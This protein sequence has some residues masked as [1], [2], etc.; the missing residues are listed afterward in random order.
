MG[1]TEKMHPF[2]LLVI[3]N[4][5]KIKHYLYVCF[6]NR[7]LE[8]NMLNNKHWIITANMGLGHLRAIYPFI[9]LALDKILLLGE[10]YTGSKREK[11]LWK[12]LQKSYEFLSR[13]QQIPLIGPYLFS[14]LEKL[15]N[16]SPFYPYRDQSQPSLQVKYLDS[17]IK[18]GLGKSMFEHVSTFNTAIITSFYAA[19]ISAEKNTALPVY[20]I[21]CDSDI[22]RV[23]VSHNPTKSRIIYFAP[24]GHAMQ[25]LKQYGV[26][27]ERIFLT[28]FPLP[29]ELVGGEDISILKH[30]LSQRLKRL[31]VSGNF[32][33]IHKNE[34]DYY[35]GDQNY[36]PQ[37]R[38]P[39]TLTYA[40]GGAGAQADIA[41]HIIKSLSDKLS[42]GLI[43]LNLVAGVRQKVKDYFEFLL[44]KQ[45]LH[46][47]PNIN[48]I[49]SPDVCKYFFMFNN[50][51]KDTDILWTKPSELSFYCALGLPI[52]AAPCIGPHEAYNLS[53]LKDVGAAVD[54]QDP[55]Y[56]SE[57]IGDMLNSGIFAQRAWNGFLYA[58]KAG[59]YKILQ[60][61]QTGELKKETHTLYK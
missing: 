58:R 40:V 39:V 19:A 17:L 53:W 44:A 52:I 48:I 18:K 33:Y 60:V 38:S 50:A 13:T 20:C 45:G 31:D 41:H 49:Y 11:Y 59:T 32:C 12:T 37:Y 26:P 3:D 42:D 16:I 15:Q 55:R 30:D 43:R 27:Q 8:D 22:N 36:S 29:H 6:H 21:I 28:G 25:R 51:L 47:C 5:N 57:W 24:C 46:G 56:C 4:C 14:V 2:N 61:L 7:E 23:W 34:I 54:Q 35:L 9:D 1:H 10:D